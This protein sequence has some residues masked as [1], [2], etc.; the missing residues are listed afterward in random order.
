MFIEA[1]AEATLESAKQKVAAQDKILTE[2]IDKLE[3]KKLND[4]KNI[5]KEYTHIQIIYHAKSVEM[6]TQAYQYLLDIDCENDLEQFRNAFRQSNLTDMIG[7]KMSLNVTQSNYDQ[8]SVMNTTGGSLPVTPQRSRANQANKQNGFGR[9]TKSN[10]NL[11]RNEDY[12]P[13]SSSR[14][15]RG[16]NKDDSGRQSKLEVEDYESESEEDDY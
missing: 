6:L 2:Q 8:Q 12:S 1:L 4:I 11:K 15:P 9:R 10:E 13:V 14:T 7:S 5:L 16:K 3:D